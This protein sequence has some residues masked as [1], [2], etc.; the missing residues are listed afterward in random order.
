MTTTTIK[1]TVQDVET[2][3]RKTLGA[4][5]ADN[6]DN[7]ENKMTTR[8]VSVKSACYALGSVVDGATFE[9]ACAAMNA[10]GS[11]TAG[12]DVIVVYRVIDGSVDGGDDAGVRVRT[13]LGKAEEDE[14]GG[15]RA[16]AIGAA[17]RGTENAVEVMYE[18]ERRRKFVMHDAEVSESN[19]LRENTFG[20][21]GCEAATRRTDGGRRASASATVRVTNGTTTNGKSAAKKPEPT[22]S[23]RPTNASTSAAKKES[24]WSGGDPGGQ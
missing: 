5:G 23:S 17:V 18:D 21:V 24:P 7:D 4:G 13:R 20:A 11:D 9:A 12:V 14:A 22:P 19:A 1:A 15:G 16:S 3:L 6:N 2:F 10:A 8:A